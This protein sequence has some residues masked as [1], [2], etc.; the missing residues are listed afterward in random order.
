V[1]SHLGGSPS[2]VSCPWCGGSGLRTPGIDA[3]AHWRSEQDEAPPTR[4][5]A[6]D[7]EPDQA[8]AQQ[9]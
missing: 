5:E 2:R 9:P 3:Q 4:G 8:R 7:G 1:I 6:G